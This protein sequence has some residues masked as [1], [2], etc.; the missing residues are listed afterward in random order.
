MET[1]AI[2][3]EEKTSTG[4]Q[5]SVVVGEGDDTTEHKVFLDEAYWESLTGRKSKPRTLIKDSFVFLLERES[6]ESILTS[7][8]LKQIEDYFPEYTKKIAS[9]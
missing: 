4:W 3:K 8:N 5:F 7:F 6:K 2:T 1:I 9:S